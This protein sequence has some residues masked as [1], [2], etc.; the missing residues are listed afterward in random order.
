MDEQSALHLGPDELAAMILLRGFFARV[1]YKR[2]AW[3]R[4]LSLQIADLQC[5]RNASIGTGNSE[6]GCCKEQLTPVEGEA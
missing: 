1:Q 4:K 5:I 6:C 3:Q 2:I